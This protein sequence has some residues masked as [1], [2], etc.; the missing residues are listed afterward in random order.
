MGENAV[1]AFPIAPWQ[2]S[3]TMYMDS[4]VTG[5]VVVPAVFRGSDF[6]VRSIEVTKYKV[7][8]KTPG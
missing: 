5:L 6:V 3:K 8:R 2:K 7:E 1:Y 4:D